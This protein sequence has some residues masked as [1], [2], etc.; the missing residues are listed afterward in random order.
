MI[1]TVKGFGVVTKAEIDVF[2]ELSCF[3]HDPADVGNLTSGSFAF[4]KTSLSIREFTVHI[5]LKVSLKDFEHNLTS[6]WNE[7]YFM[8]V[9]I[10]FVIALHWDWNKNW[11]LPVLWPQL[12]FPNLLTYDCSTLTA[13]SLGILN[14]STRIPSP[15]LALFVVMLLNTHL[16]SHSRMFASWWVITP[17]LLSGSFRSFLYSSSMY[18]YHL[19]LI[20]FASVRSILFLSFVVPVYL[21]DIL[22]YL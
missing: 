17:S 16:T 13:L 21:H 5:L 11:P 20:S 6:I 9:W 10:F 19:F 12:S 14:S 18:S 22:W 2:L 4:S 8:L 7:K 15:P 3:F 1:H